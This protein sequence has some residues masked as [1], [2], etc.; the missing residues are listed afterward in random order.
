MRIVEKV[1]I[2]SFYSSQRHILSL[3]IVITL[4]GIGNNLFAQQEEMQQKITAFSDDQK[5]N[6]TKK[7]LNIAEREIGDIEG[8]GYEWKEQFMLKSKEKK[9][10][11]I[12]NK[13]YEK[14]Y[15]SIY[16][17]AGLED[18][19][20]GLKHWMQNFIE[21]KKIR[22]G[23]KVRTYEYATPTIVLINDMNIVVCNY[24]CSTF[25]EENF[26]YWKKTMLTYFGDSKTMVIEVECD[27]P[28]EWTKNAPDPKMSRKLF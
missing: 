21:G 22:P 25:T 1:I 16:G 4:S 28:L 12:G 5:E 15:F 3:A 20:Y 23:R 18:R 19:Q 26:K 9:V 24:K 8:S 11:N 14:F 13:S 2:R 7:Y 27:G 10:N 6:Y 17:Y